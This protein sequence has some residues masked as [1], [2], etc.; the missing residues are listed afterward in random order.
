MRQEGKLVGY[1]FNHIVEDELHV[2]N[3]A[4][5]PNSRGKGLGTYLLAT[6]LAKAFEK[7][8]RQVYLE[9]RPSNS[10]A[11]N[12]YSKLGFLR[13]GLRKNYYRDNGEDALL[14]ELLLTEEEARHFGELSVFPKNR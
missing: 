4:V 12:L 13:T 14:F 6:V 7:G 8:A 2:L 11:I 5:D 9:V 3:I 1:A 10:A